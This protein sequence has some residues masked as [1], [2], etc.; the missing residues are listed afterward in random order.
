M[1]GTGTSDPYCICNIPG[2]TKVKKIQTKVMDNTVTPV[3]NH[4]DAMDG[5]QDGDA[6]E[7]QIYD[8]DTANFDD[9]LGKV[10]LAPEKIAQ[11]FDGE[12]QVEDAGKGMEAFLKVQVS[13]FAPGTGPKPAA[14]AQPVQTSP[15]KKVWITIVSARGLRDADSMIG[16]GTS[17]PYCICSNVA[18]PKLKKIQTKTLDNTVTPV[19]NHSAVM[20]G[21]QDGD[22]LEFVVF[23]SDTGTFDD[24]LGKVKMT[25]ECIAKGC[26]LSPCSSS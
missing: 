2:K 14:T 23:D 20:D 18:K 10:R 11:G 9:V 6:L 7:F 19:W 22:A 3:W 21:Y 25:P 15:P 8:S 1:I 4:S 24:V 5:Y 12:L 17:D 26:N 13:L 16:T